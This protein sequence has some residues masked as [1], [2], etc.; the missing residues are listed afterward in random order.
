VQAPLGQLISPRTTCE[1][2]NN[3]VEEDN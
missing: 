2:L 1:S 3:T